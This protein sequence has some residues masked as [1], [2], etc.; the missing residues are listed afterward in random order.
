VAFHSSAIAVYKP[1]VYTIS[2][3]PFKFDRHRTHFSFVHSLRD[4]SSSGACPQLMEPVH[5]NCICEAVCLLR[6]TC[7]RTRCREIRQ[8]FG[9]S[10]AEK[11]FFIAAARRSFGRV[12][13]RSARLVRAAS[14]AS[15]QLAVAR[16]ACV[17]LASQQEVVVFVVLVVRC[18]CRGATAFGVSC[19]T[20][21]LLYVLIFSLLFHRKCWTMPSFVFLDHML[22]AGM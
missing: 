19:T 6:F 8:L 14:L 2:H 10:V 22:T 21:L 5:N 16:G 13:R 20:C 3:Q 11:L 4:V 18:R 12:R 1:E 17:V 15:S 9:L 7:R